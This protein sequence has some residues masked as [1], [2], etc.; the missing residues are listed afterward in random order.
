MS[1]H[2]G[3]RRSEPR[4]DLQ[5][6]CK[7]WDPRS[8]K[9]HTGSTRNVSRSGMLLEIDRPLW[10]ASGDEIFVGVAARRRDSVLLRRE[11]AEAQ[12]VR[13]ALTPTDRTVIAIRG[14][15]PFASVAE[16]VAA[17]AGR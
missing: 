9:Y 14:S 7:V 10:L 12:V 3:E 15:S 5:R 13:T 6:P 11:M 2:D 1:T 16:P 17:L 4:H 8:G